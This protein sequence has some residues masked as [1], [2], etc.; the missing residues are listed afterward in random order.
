M[1]RDESGWDQYRGYSTSDA[2]AT[3]PF[4]GAKAIHSRPHKNGHRIEIR[5]EDG[6]N[7]HLYGKTPFTAYVVIGKLDNPTNRKE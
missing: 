5:T 3:P 4:G 7:T 1:V 6:R 2:R